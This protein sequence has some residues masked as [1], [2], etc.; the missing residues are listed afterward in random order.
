MA[1]S[2]DYDLTGCTRRGIEFTEF[3]RDLFAPR[4]MPD[5]T[6]LKWFGFSE[7]CVGEELNALA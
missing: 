7:R 5:A 3:N 2:E 6:R 1:E 4:E